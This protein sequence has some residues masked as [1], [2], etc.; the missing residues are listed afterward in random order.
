MKLILL[1]KTFLLFHLTVTVSCTYS[2]S[3]AYV[4]K[5]TGGYNDIMIVISPELKAS[6]CPRIL[7][8][9]KVIYFLCLK[10]IWNMLRFKTFC[11]YAY[12]IG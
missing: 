1:Y 8:D 6:D 7:E 9:I 10:T 11:H 4:D 5:E 12:M 2:K 3:R